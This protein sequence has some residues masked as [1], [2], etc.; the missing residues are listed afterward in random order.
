[1][2]SFEDF[3]SDI[4]EDL[5]NDVVALP[6]QYS[7]GMTLSQPPS[8]VPVTQVQSDDHAEQNYKQVSSSSRIKESLTFCSDPVLSDVC[9]VQ[10]CDAIHEA[11]HTHGIA[12][13]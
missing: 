1:M 13:T 5:M 9:R 4:D 3:D 11:W 7:R 12:F 8:Q 10:Q 2:A 6:S